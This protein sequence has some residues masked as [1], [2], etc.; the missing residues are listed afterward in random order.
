MSHMILYATAAGLRAVTPVMLG[1]ELLC[2]AIA[3]GSR[4][5][6]RLHRQAVPDRAQ[7]PRILDVQR[8][9]LKRD[10]VSHGQTTV[11]LVVSETGHRRD[12]PPRD[13]LLDENHATPHCTVDAASHVES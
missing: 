12:R 10:P 2:G 6:G 13:N 8:A 1:N 5:A 3:H 11:I 7:P 9:L 4:R